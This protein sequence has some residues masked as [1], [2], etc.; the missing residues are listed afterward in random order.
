MGAFL[1]CGSIDVMP[2][3]GAVRG[4]G[5]EALR[6]RDTGGDPGCPAAKPELAEVIVAPREP[7]A[8]P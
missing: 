5:I 8:D 4:S 7:L 6:F 3:P 2:H 1:S